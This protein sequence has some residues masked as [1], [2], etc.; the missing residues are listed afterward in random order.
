ML[1]IGNEGTI[2]IVTGLA[3][4]C[5]I[6][7]LLVL[8]KSRQV[9]AQKAEM[10]KRS[11][12]QEG[13]QVISF[14]SGHPEYPL[15]QGNLGAHDFMNGRQSEIGFPIN[16]NQTP[17]NPNFRPS[18]QS[19]FSGMPKASFPPANV[20]QYGGQPQNQFP[21]QQPGFQATTQPQHPQTRMASTP[22]PRTR[23]DDAIRARMMGVGGGPLY[24][25]QHMGP[26]PTRMN[27]PG[28]PAQN[29]N[30]SNPNMMGQAQYGSQSRMQ[31]AP[32]MD[33]RASLNPMH[34]S[35]EAQGRIRMNH[36]PNTNPVQQM[37]PNQMM[38]SGR[39]ADPNST[40]LMNRMSPQNQIPS[41]RSMANNMFNPQQAANPNTMTM[42]PRDSALCVVEIRWMQFLI[43]V[44]RANLRYHHLRTTYQV[45]H[46][47]EYS[48][49]SGMQ[50]N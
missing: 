39:P 29:P 30:S 48:L 11:R 9:K 25:Q 31:P 10:D 35:I 17:Q 50:C 43:L 20:Q 36:L 49:R 8:L 45:F 13:G 23:S 24:A 21:V 42:S 14:G 19:F 2:G 18:A 5:C 26:T 27:S 41:N 40:Q 12:V 28:M 16:H 37:Q 32:V 47:F 15:S 46:R 34:M 7:G 1:G 4:V 3:V 44:R 33:G 38:M 22:D 6:L